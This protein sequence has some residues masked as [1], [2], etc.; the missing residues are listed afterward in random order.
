[1]LILLYIIIYICSIRACTVNVTTISHLLHYVCDCVS[2]YI[3]IIFMLLAFAFAHSNWQ[4]SVVLY[5]GAF[6]GDLFDGMAARYF[7]QCKLISCKGDISQHSYVSCC[8]GDIFDI[9]CLNIIWLPSCLKL[10]SKALN[11]VAF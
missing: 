4:L 5:L 2:G 3:R 9:A 7:N 10:F 8:V 11:L 1:M 6:T